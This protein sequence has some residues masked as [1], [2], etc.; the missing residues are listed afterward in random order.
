[1]Q[2]V[3]DTSIHAVEFVAIHHSDPSNGLHQSM[4]ERFGIA[5]NVALQFLVPEVLC[6]I[7]SSIG[8]SLS[9]HLA[10]D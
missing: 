3:F 9:H 10:I 7:D 5:H 2:C 1:M 8:S 4:V 6:H